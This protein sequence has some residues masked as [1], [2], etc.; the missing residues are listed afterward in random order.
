MAWVGDQAAVA[1]DCAAPTYLYSAGLHGWR[2]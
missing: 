2:R 1:I